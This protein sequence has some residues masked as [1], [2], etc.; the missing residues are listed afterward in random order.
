MESNAFFHL[1]EVQEEFSRNSDRGVAVVIAS[2]LDE[3]LKEVLQNFLIKDDKNDKEIFEGNGPLSSFS[4]KITLCYRLGLISQYEFKIIN[5]I[6]AIR[7]DFAHHL[8]GISFETQSIKQKCINICIPDHLFH[9]SLIPL[10][11]NEGAIAPVRVVR[12]DRNN[13]R[14]LFQETSLQLMHLLLG[15]TIAALVQSRKPLAEYKSATEPA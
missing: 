6:R 9:P 15:R 11:N 4:S 14:E 5:T 7:N 3:I 1:H 8:G 12:A 2:L 10:P 13:P